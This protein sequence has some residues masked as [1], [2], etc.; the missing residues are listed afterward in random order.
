MQPLSHT[1]LRMPCASVLFLPLLLHLL[2]L[3]L[4]LVSQAS[5]LMVMRHRVRKNCLALLW[6]SPGSGCGMP[7]ASFQAALGRWSVE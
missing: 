3:P 6:S 5:K 2:F 1:A 4:L 7:S